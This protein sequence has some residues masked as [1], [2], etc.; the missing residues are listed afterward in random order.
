MKQSICIKLLK[1]S[2]ELY[3]CVIKFTNDPCRTSIELSFKTWTSAKI[4][5]SFGL[6]LPK[7]GRGFKSPDESLEQG[8]NA[9]R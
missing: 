5:K 2:A 3:E 8:R 6:P 1:Q 9:S 7:F 4:C